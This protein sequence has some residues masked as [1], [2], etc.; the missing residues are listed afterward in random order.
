MLGEQV[1]TERRVPSASSR[2]VASSWPP[3]LAPEAMRRP[4]SSTP[5]GEPT[6]AVSPPA[7]LARPAR[8]HTRLLGGDLPQLQQPAIDSGYLLDRFPVAMVVLD[9]AL[10]PFRPLARHGDLLCAPSWEADGD[11]Q[12]GVARPLG[13]STVGFPTADLALEEAAPENLLQ[14]RQCLQHPG[15]APQQGRWRR[16]GSRDLQWPCLYLSVIYTD[17]RSR[18]HK[19]PRI[20]EPQ[21]RALPYPSG[22]TSGTP[23]AVKHT[24]QAPALPSRGPFAT[25]PRGRWSQ[26]AVMA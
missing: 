17:D 4:E 10:H 1:A 3:G 9:P 11:A 5:A 19:C 24:A 18:S 14:G 20:P 13:T 22:R 21:R 15:S 16:I 23:R 2:T 25:V 26:R 7:P 8:W 12:Q 6:A